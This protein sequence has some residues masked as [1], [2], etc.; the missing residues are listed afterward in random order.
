[1]ELTG[2]SSYCIDI[3]QKLEKFKSLKL[4]Y[5]GFPLSLPMEFRAPVLRIILMRKYFQET[6]FC[7]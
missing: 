4:D 6:I 7:T 1:M 2:I 3:R 5:D